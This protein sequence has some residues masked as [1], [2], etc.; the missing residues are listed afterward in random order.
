MNRP[1][2]LTPQGDF[3]KRLDTALVQLQQ[4]S[5]ELASHPQKV[6]A[7]LKDLESSVE[8]LF[9]DYEDWLH[10][11]GL[12]RRAS[13]LSVRGNAVL[14]MGRLSE[15]Q[16]IYQQALSFLHNEPIPN[17]RRCSLLSGLGLVYL[18]QGLFKEAKR[19]FQQAYEEGIVLAEMYEQLAQD[20]S[21]TSSQQ[22]SLMARL[23]WQEAAQ[24]RSQIGVCALMQ[25]DRASFTTFFQEA[26]AL[27]QTHG[28]PDFSSQLRFDELKWRFYSDSDSTGEFTEELKGKLKEEIQKVQ[29]DARMYIDLTLLDVE[30]TMFT[31]SQLTESSVQSVLKDLEEAEDR[32]LTNDLPAS[33]RL[34]ILARIGVLEANQQIDEAIKQAENLLQVSQRMGI[35]PD[36]EAQ[37][38]LIRVHLKSSDAA[39]QRQAVQ[40]IEEL[41]KNGNTQY[42][43]QVLSA[44]AQF[45]SKQKRFED[46]L[47]DIERA[48]TCALENGA[49][50]RKQLLFEKFVL[51]LKLGRTSE[52]LV[53]G[54]EAIT[55]YSEALLPPNRQLQAQW[56]DVL[57]RLE[58]LY[59]A[60]AQLLVDMDQPDHLRQALAMA[61]Q[62]KAQILRQQL[63]WSGEQ[64]NQ[65]QAVGSEIDFDQLRA[66]L[67]SESAA[68]AM[69]SLEDALST[70]DKADDKADDAKRK[71]RSWIFVVDPQY[72]EPRYYPLDKS[73]IGILRKYTSMP[74]SKV[75]R[76]QLFNEVLPEL[77]KH[78]LPHLREV[79]QNCKVLYLVPSSSLYQ[80]PFAALS[81]GDDTYLIEHCAL[82]YVPSIAA[83]YWCR[84]RYRSVAEHTYAL[85]E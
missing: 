66:T 81:F 9:Q 25:D 13:I 36:P 22:R 69:F 24:R 2:L 16:Q 12:D 80:I 14:L 34:V 75:T 41:S 26:Q 8:F 31:G 11:Q 48:E 37:S 83:L 1:S 68:L 71:G 32:A 64:P 28:L 54:K 53:Q 52:A 6:D 77:S 33:Q 50:E 23:A 47:R 57:R 46:A 3:Q 21:G 20:T 56:K 27:A 78:L 7:A 15:A 61:E 35:S 84:S 5:R 39:Q 18:Q 70:D 40:E 76:W 63:V 51:L 85:C 60:M 17:A 67:A 55:R 79:V 42:L 73:V 10:R 62:G 72:Q 43:A 30:L 49:Y 38:V 4:I 82:T 19:S 45:H 29:D 44:R 59:T 58:S 65:A 74:D